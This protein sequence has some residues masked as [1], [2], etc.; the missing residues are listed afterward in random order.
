MEQADGGRKKEGRGG[1]WNEFIW[2]LKAVV[3]LM[4]LYEKG[5]SHYDPDTPTHFPVLSLL[6]KKANR[7]FQNKWLTCREHTGHAVNSF[8]C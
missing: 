1:L 7:V 5:N 8:Q 4:I 6:P 2:N 3:I